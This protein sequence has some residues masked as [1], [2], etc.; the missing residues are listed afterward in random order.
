MITAVACESLSDRD[1]GAAN[2]P[3]GSLAQALSTD[4]Q[5]C[6]TVQ[7]GASGQAEDVTLWQAAPTWNDGANERI[8]TGTSATGGYS[9]SLL[10]FDLGG[11]PAGATV[12]SA[13]LSLFQNYKSGSNS[14]VS[15]LRATAPW[16]EGT[17]TWSSFGAAFDPAPVATFEVLGGGSSGTRAIDVRGLVQDWIS[18][19]AP[20]YGLV[21]DDLTDPGATEFRSSN[22]PYVTQ[23][24]ALT[25]CYVTCDDGAQ[26]GEETG[27]D[28]G[29]PHC[30][31]CNPDPG[32]PMGPPIEPSGTSLL[33]QVV[34]PAGAPIAGATVEVGGVEVPTDALGNALLED[35][36][37]GAAVAV[38]RAPGFAPGTVAAALESAVHGGTTISLRPLGPP[39][40]FDADEDATVVADAVQVELPAGS[41]LD[42]DGQPVTGTA[43]IAFA[44]LD[45]TTDDIA[46]A[47][48]PFLGV[49]APGAEPVLLESGYMAEIQLTQDGR[50]LQLAP[51]AT[52]TITF[53]LPPDFAATV[54]PG[55]LIQ[56]WW[57]DHAEG[58]WVEEGF[59]VVEPSPEDPNV[60]VWTAEV[61]HFSSWNCDRP[62]ETQSCVNVT[63][64]D[65][66]GAPLAGRT[67]TA[68]GV[69]YGYQRSEVTGQAGTACVPVKRNGTA[70]ITVGSFWDP[71]DTITVT[72]SAQ[73][74][75]GTG[76][77]ESVTLTVNVPCGAPGTIQ[78]CAYTG[79]GEPGQ[80]ACKVGR[81]VCNGY[82]WGAC[83]GQVNATSEVCE[84][85]VDEDCDGRLN[86]GCEE[87]E[88]DDPPIPCYSGP[89][90]T[91]NA[92]RCQAG[93]RRCI[94][95]AWGPC[96]GEVTPQPEDCS[97]PDDEDC[98]GDPDDGCICNPDGSLPP[99]YTGPDGTQGVGVC[100]SGYKS[101]VR[102]G[103]RGIWTSC[104]N[105]VLPAPELCD[106]LDNDCDGDID[107]G[108]P[109][110]GTS[111]ETG[112]PGVCAAGVMTCSDGQLR[113]VSA[114]PAS[115]EI[116]D[117]LDNDC[118][119]AVDEDIVGLGSSCDTG[120]PGRCA[121]GTTS[122]FSGIL[123]CV[124][125]DQ[126]QPEDCDTGEDDDCDG[127]VNEGCPSHLTHYSY[128][129]SDTSSATRNTHNHTVT[130]PE[131]TTVSIGTCGVPGA[132]ASGDTW[133]R[134]FNPFGVEVAS[135]DDSCNSLSTFLMY[136]V[137]PGGGGNYVIRSGCFS[138]HSCSGTVGIAY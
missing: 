126:P 44:P 118:D 13:T 35:L 90:G 86:N 31:P 96:E 53:R 62:I 77:C 17:S 73:A 107:E 28:C 8:R 52:A 16:S 51:G 69:D 133:L 108:N 109:G 138:G 58:V 7:R 132:S 120:T 33:I 74:T 20:N 37:P 24:P 34:D 93:V 23:R 11:V 94:D 26:N 12:V 102:Q 116:C 78:E 6:L 91:E 83:V 117:G 65:Q 87:C 135:N 124:Q 95:G 92:G 10:R 88:E 97:M 76:G 84:N 98:D 127:Q 47:P 121:R 60:L 42:D 43:E 29:G 112:Q 41:L 22:S 122:C 57:F 36:A 14:I 18:S 67:V 19:E 55:D 85:G 105:E 27:F 111:C 115:D 82:T 114:A 128:S 81:R 75:C 1:D 119:A 21:L 64:Q 25:V 137:P 110:G 32:P 125:T 59:G 54:A 131:G 39:I 49:T 63:V 15:V 46:S 38:V 30:G 68:R 71:Q 79:P 2:E 61:S 45:P 103:Y 104:K 89:P 136:Q 101:C 134:L 80:G 123:T 4:R 48:G 106:G 5:V 50:P 66:D 130:L 40:A 99:C 100:K 3:S 9:R 72:P 56:S 70:M 113:C 129:A